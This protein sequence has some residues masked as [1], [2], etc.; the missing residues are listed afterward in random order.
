MQTVS[1]KTQR[2]THIKNRIQYD[3]QNT[4]LWQ[5]KQIQKVHDLNDILLDVNNIPCKRNC[6]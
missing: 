1:K 5:R 4:V 2:D 6:K 3:L